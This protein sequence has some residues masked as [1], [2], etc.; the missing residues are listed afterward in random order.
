VCSP[1]FQP[2][3]QG[4]G[5]ALPDMQDFRDSSRISPGGG[6]AKRALA[7]GVPLDPNP[8]RILLLKMSITNFVVE[9]L[10]ENLADFKEK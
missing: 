2:Q 8:L 4:G 10:R 3:K 7:T 5:Q 6:E 9:R 1:G